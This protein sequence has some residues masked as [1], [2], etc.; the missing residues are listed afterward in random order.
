MPYCSV[1]LGVIEKSCQKLVLSS[2][3]QCLEPLMKHEARVFDILRTIYW[4]TMLKGQF[5]FDQGAQMR[6]NF[7]ETRSSFN[8]LIFWEEIV[9][10][11]LE[12]TIK[13]HGITHKNE[14]YCFYIFACTKFPYGYSRIWIFNS[15]EFCK[16]A[17]LWA[18]WGSKEVLR[19]LK[20]LDNSTAEEKKTPSYL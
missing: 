17:R 12:Q 10:I 11:V 3:S 19:W 8:C 7:R 6:N 15:T 4:D 14:F 16:I 2:V 5:S 13:F 9:D 1:I 18:Y 20:A